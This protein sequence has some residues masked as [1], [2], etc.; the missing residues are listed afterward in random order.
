MKAKSFKY[1][2]TQDLHE[3]FGIRRIYDLVLLSEWLSATNEISKEEIEQLELLRIGLNKN[4]EFWNEEELKMKF[5]GPLIEFV[6]IDSD[7]F[8]TFYDRPIRIT[9][10]EILL[11]GTLDMVIATGFQV[12]K[13][14]FFC[15]HEYKQE[16]KRDGDPKGQLLAEMIALQAINLPDENP[17]YGCYVLDRNWFFVVL[18]GHEYAVSNALDASQEDVFIIFKMLKKVKEYIIEIIKKDS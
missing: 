10:N 3:Q 5:I 18:K 13:K 4:A 1:W 12:P 14:P 2:I 17:V 11:S 15:V 8:R 9:V 6:K 7:S 16:S